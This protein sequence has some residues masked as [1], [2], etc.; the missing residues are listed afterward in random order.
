MQQSSERNVENAA[1][2]LDVLMERGHLDS[3][4][5]FLPR[6]KLTTLLG[7]HVCGTSFI[8]FN[9]RIKLFLTAKMEPIS[10]EKVV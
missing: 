5:T 8:L 10:Q 2:Y 6:A 7:S 3:I 1:H 4:L 9:L